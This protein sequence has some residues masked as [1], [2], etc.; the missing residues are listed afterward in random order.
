MDM[1]T[2]NLN[3]AKTAVFC[4]RFP[5]GETHV[6]LA[7]HWVKFNISCQMFGNDFYWLQKRQ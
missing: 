7:S 2:L 6:L 5:D 1:S 4:D 3:T